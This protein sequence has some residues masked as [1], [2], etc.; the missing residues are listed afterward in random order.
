MD[1]LDRIGSIDEY[2]E[3]RKYL[4]RSNLDLDDLY[5]EKKPLLWVHIPFEYNAR[6]WQSFGSRSSTDLN[7][8]Y[9]YLTLRSII[10]NCDESF[11][12]IVIDDTTFGKL[13]PDW[14]TNLSNIG[15]PLREQ[16]RCI[17][18]TKLLY[19][20]GGLA[21]P[22]SFLCFRDL[23]GMYRKGLNEHTGQMFVS[24]SEENENQL[25]LI[26]AHRENKVMSELIHFLEKQ[27][28][29][30]AT[31]YSEKKEVRS[32]LNKKHRE[33][34]LNL[35][36][37]KDIGIMTVE[38]NRVYIDDLLGESYI[39]FFP[40]MYGIW[41]P[42]KTLM[43]RST[44]EWFIRLD[45]KQLLKSHFI[46]AKYFVLALAPKEYKMNERIEKEEHEEEEKK[47]NSWIS[48]WR[49]PSH[50]NLYG[51]KPIGL[52]QIVPNMGQ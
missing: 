26:G 51:M 32:W 20:Y 1:K 3:I 7:Q 24:E 2:Y 23:I 5:K 33:R 45:K 39:H 30:M 9:L 49:V 25:G 4:L 28:S 47:R 10:E 42:S 13:L 52:S 14:K 15:N 31:E 12:I 40:K 18:M 16:M 48:F 22:I 38:G 19:T 37:G 46:L 36:S 43:N 21:V 44:Y 8:P 35:I 27:V 29:S 11:K 41:V 6:S 50:I 34:Q 17:A